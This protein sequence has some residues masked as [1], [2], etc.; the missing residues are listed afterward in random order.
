[1]SS[2]SVRWRKVRA[3]K[4]KIDEWMVLQQ[5]QLVL[6]PEGQ[7]Y[8]RWLFLARRFKPCDGVSEG[9]FRVSCF[10]IEKSNGSP[11]DYMNLPPELVVYL[12]DFLAEI[13]RDLLVQGV[14]KT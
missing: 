13:H 8:P 11:L 9:G 10:F 4:T 1:M 2:K 14:V 6:A 5:W 3:R 7:L 12:S